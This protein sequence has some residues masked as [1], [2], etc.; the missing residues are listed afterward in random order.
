ME[1]ITLSMAFGTSQ[2]NCDFKLY[3]EQQM[4]NDADFSVYQFS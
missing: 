4:N 2:S 3:E 1:M